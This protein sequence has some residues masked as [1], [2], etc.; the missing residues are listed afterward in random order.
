MGQRTKAI[1]S[2]TLLDL[3][4]QT[5]VLI[6]EEVHVS[7]CFINMKPERQPSMLAPKHCK[8]HGLIHSL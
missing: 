1:S 6:F 4:W 7:L 3:P 2:G 8:R 5:A